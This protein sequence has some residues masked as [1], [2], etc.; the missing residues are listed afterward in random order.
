MTDLR[1][2]L[3]LDHPPKSVVGWPTF[4]GAKPAYLSTSADTK[5]RTRSVR[6]GLSV[7]G[8]WWRDWCAVLSCPAKKL[9]HAFGHRDASCLVV[10]GGAVTAGVRLTGGHSAARKLGPRAE[11]G[12]RPRYLT[13][14]PIALAQ[15]CPGPAR[16]AALTRWIMG[17]LAKIRGPLAG[18]DLLLLLP[19]PLAE[20]LFP[21]FVLLLGR[22]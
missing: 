16:P 6:G 17:Q 19:F 22:R 9:V 21:A 13:F 20:E 5:S 11:K 8:E 2:L 12:V 3:H 1:P 18:G 10:V 14:A 4:R 7:V 15:A